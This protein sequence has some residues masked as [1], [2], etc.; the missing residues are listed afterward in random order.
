MTS[1]PSSHVPSEEAKWWPREPSGWGGGGAAARPERTRRPGPSSP[2]TARGPQLRRVPAWRLRPGEPG[3]RFGG[4]GPRGREQG[5]HYRP[6]LPVP[7]PQPRVAPRPGP[8]RRDEEG[9]REELG[10]R[11]GAGRRQKGRGGAEAWAGKA[12]GAGQSGPL[13]RRRALRWEFQMEGD[14]APPGASPRGP[15]RRGRQGQPLT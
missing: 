1:G 4:G 8:P 14:P 7:R 2:R 5:R 10:G 3:R 15:G 13:L 11:G 9:G 12:A 6:T